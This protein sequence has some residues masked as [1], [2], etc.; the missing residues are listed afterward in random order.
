MA[1][2]R[3]KEHNEN[4]DSWVIVINPN[5]AGDRTGSKWP[6]I[7]QEL[8]K[9]IPQFTVHFTNHKGHATQITRH[10]INHGAKNI[11][12]IGGDG[13]IS[14]VAAGF[15]TDDHKPIRKPGEVSLGILASGTGSD[16]IRTF[17][18]PSNIKR[19]ISDFSNYTTK[20][21][22]AGKASYK[23]FENK[24]E[25][26]VFINI[27]EVGIGGEV[28]KILDEQ[29]KWAWGWL[30]YQLATLR[31]LL[32]HKSK[33][34]ELSFKSYSSDRSY[35]KEE[36]MKGIFSGV[37]VANG[38]Y[39]GSGMKVAPNA[40][41]SDGLFDVVIIGNI[42]RT[43]M[44]LKS[45]MIRSGTHIKDPKVQVIS[46]DSISIKGDESTL[47]EIDGEL[48]GTCPVQFTLLPRSLSLFVPKNFNS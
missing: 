41:V 28:I 32:N 6:S 44:V 18:I 11:I 16:F 21:I 1:D 15:F 46:T 33:A 4:N 34:L 17:S 13:T 37:I 47:L 19:A 38:K 25:Q 29:G 14:E 24:T 5:S 10:A 36:Q 12:G 30:S 23:N 35:Q 48:C 9:V 3:N 7:E 2:I 42:S 39:Y 45:S 22:D 31:G 43:E 26:R 27:G 8:R 40:Q 20:I